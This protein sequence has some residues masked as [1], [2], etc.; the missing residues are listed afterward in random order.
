MKIKAY[1]IFAGIT[2][3]CALISGGFSVARQQA[4][5]SRNQ[6]RQKALALIAQY[7]DVHNCWLLKTKKPLT[8][9]TII[10]IPTEG[11][12]PTGC[13]FNEQHYAYAAYHQGRLRIQFVFT[14]LE[15][16]REFSVEKLREHKYEETKE[17]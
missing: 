10:S 3:A 4:S 1:T 16:A 5:V 15:V 2:V 17:N 7:K 11:K 13:F 12:S 14:N 6:E 8:I 9:G